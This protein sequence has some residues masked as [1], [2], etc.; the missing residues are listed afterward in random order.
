MERW[1]RTVS[2]FVCA[3]WHRKSQCR[4]DATLE[5]NCEPG[6]QLSHGQLDLRGRS[7]P[8]PCQDSADLRSRKQ[9]PDTDVRISGRQHRRRI[10]VQ[11]LERRQL[12]QWWVEWRLGQRWKQWR[13]EWGK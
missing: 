8:G 11:R 3:L 1:Q 10:S 4:C 5:R 9:W 2:D 6:K 12:G 7:R 13:M